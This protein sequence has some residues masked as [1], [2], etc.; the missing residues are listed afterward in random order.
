MVA[1][2]I[3]L[4]LA[5]VF[6]VLCM[7]CCTRPNYKCLDSCLVYSHTVLFVAAVALLVAFFTA[8]LINNLNAEATAFLVVGAVAAAAMLLVQVF[9]CYRLSAQGYRPADFAN[10]VPA[11]EKANIVADT[12]PIDRVRVKPLIFK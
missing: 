10:M 4:V 5:F 2:I 11:A 12:N 8:R 7:C 9:L 6:W 3:I 1:A